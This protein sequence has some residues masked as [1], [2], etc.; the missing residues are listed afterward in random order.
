MT[1]EIG[2]QPLVRL[3]ADVLAMKHG[4]PQFQWGSQSLVV[5]SGTRSDYISALQA[6]DAG[7]IQPLLTFARS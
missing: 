7:N 3:M 5:A 2:S 4:R 1:V 6:A